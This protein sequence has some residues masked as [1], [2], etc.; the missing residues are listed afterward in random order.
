MKKGVRN[1]DLNFFSKNKKNEN[2]KPYSLPLQIFGK[3]WVIPKSTMN[4]ECGIVTG[5][6]NLHDIFMDKQLHSSLTS[7]RTI[8]STEK[9][10]ALGRNFS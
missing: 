9:C 6:Q 10:K 4:F 1:V 3:V 7:P 5:Y 8:P 2:T